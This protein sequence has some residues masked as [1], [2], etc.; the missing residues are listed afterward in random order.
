MSLLQLPLIIAKA[1]TH[2]ELQEEVIT[3]CLLRILAET[4]SSEVRQPRLPQIQSLRLLIFTHQDVLLVAKTGFGKSLIFH[5]YTILTGKITIQLIP[6]SK[7]GEEQAADISRLEGARPCL[8][9]K[10]TIRAEKALLERV[11]AGDFTH[12]LLGPEQASR[13]AFRKILRRPEFQDRIGLVAID[14]CHLLNQWRDFRPEITMISEL[15]TIL[16]QDVVWFGCSAT[17]D[18]KDESHVLNTAGFRSVGTGKHRTEVIRTSVDRPDISISVLP[19]A[20][21]KLTSWDSLYFLLNMAVTDGVATPN[22]IPKTIVFIDGRLSVHAAAAWTIDQLLHIS[23]DY[24]IHSDAGDK[25]VHEVVQIFTARVAQY[26][27]DRAYAEFGKPYSK[28]RIMFATTSLGLGIN[29]VDVVRVVT[30]RIPITKS[31]G[32]I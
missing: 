6:L 8:L 19:L 24:S 30:W 12:L 17:M 28:I 3:A 13:R 2:V 25:C 18:A 15:R 11:A 4:S 5:A 23:T 16:H 31:L 22:E 26:D 29:I 14:E 1:R 21:G 27:R 32:D 7:L 9:T 10:D 20:R